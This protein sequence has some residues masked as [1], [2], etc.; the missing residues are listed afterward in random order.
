MQE[1]CVVKVGSGSPK[2]DQTHGLRNET[3]FQLR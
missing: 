2:V 1:P 3:Y